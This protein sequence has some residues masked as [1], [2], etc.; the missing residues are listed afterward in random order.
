MAHHSKVALLFLLAVLFPTA[1]S[2]APFTIISSAATLGTR[3]YIDIGNQYFDDSIGPVTTP[4]PPL[5]YSLHLEA[6]D[7]STTFSADAFQTWTLTPYAISFSSTALGS[8]GSGFPGD[9]NG[10]A[11][12][13]Y[14]LLIEVTQTFDFHFSWHGRGGV[15]VVPYFGL[16]DA[17]ILSPD[18]F[19]DYII[20]AEDT[21]I[22]TSPSTVDTEQYGTLLPGMYWMGGSDSSSTSNATPGGTS[23]FEFRVVPEPNTAALLAVGLVALGVR[24]RATGPSRR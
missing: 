14:S 24:W 22:L 19:D 13:S 23:S 2:S 1:V 4:G 7:G 9:S 20:A 10:D 16:V 18:Y 12:H 15:D 5:D 17:S 8:G 3:V 11:W 21:W 6:H